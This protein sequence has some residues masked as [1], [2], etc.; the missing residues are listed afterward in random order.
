MPTQSEVV[1]HNLEFYRKQAKALLRASKAGDSK[2]T[3]RLHLY[4]PKLK[5][6]AVPALHDAQLAVAREQGFASWPRFRAFLVESNLNFQELVAAFIDAAVSDLQRAEALRV[7][8]PKVANAGF[9]VGLVLGDHVLV[10]R[11]VTETP[12]LV[13]A[14]SGPQDCVP[15]LYVCF[16]RYAN[17]Q[18]VR[19]AGLLATAQVLLR[20]GADPNASFTPEDLPDNPLSCLYAASGINNNPA[21]TLALLEA[22]ANPNDNESLY[23]STEHHDLA[24]MKL[25]LRHGAKV[26]GS[27]ALKHML[28][29]EDSEG[30][31]LLLNAGGDPN[32][33]NE[34]GNTALHWA[35]W[36]GRSVKIVTTLLD[37][38]ADLNVR[39]HDGRTAYALAVLSGQ[40]EVAAFLQS[41]GAKT[42]L[43]ALDQFVEQAGHAGDPLAAL[44]GVSS[45]PGYQNLIPHLASVHNTSAV[46]GL[47]AA[48]LPVDARGEHGGT[49]LHWASWKGYADLVKLL[50][51]HHASLDI[52][53]QAF[54][55]TP[56]GWLHH[57]TRNCGE[58]GG[59]HAEVA[60]LL[61]AAGDS[62]KDCNTPTGNAEVDAVL[63]EHKLLE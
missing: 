47:L 13:N 40:K 45:Q 39:R 49:A 58:P 27:N 15:L 46:R 30:L 53:D 52:K 34:Q 50:L 54:H 7:A 1:R 23:H 14:K 18:S 31:Q 28:D 17:G 33:T 57:G 36:R 51:D 26:D 42:D 48:G 20:H 16:S 8:N 12:A 61:I 56:S 37:H 2:A 6:S 35:V 19:S 62:M 11:T 25:L 9:Y 4:S 60:R 59:D 63:R 55:A 29:R 10:E 44:P 41:R 32:E 38:G 21:L 24:C 43:S 3:Q 5:T 22:G